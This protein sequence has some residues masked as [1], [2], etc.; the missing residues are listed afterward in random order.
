M[1]RLAGVMLPGD[2]NELQLKAAIFKK[3]QIV[4]DRKKQHPNRL[5]L[6]F[7]LQ[8]NLHL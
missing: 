3:L 1:L 6:G 2:R 7:M 8:P 5:F 4:S